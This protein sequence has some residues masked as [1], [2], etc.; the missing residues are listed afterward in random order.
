[1]VLEEHTSIWLKLKLHNEQVNKSSSVYHTTIK[2]ATVTTMV[3]V[4]IKICICR[5]HSTLFFKKTSKYYFSNRATCVIPQKLFIERACIVY[6][7]IN[8]VK[9]V[10]T[11]TSS[12]LRLHPTQW[13][14]K[15]F[16]SRLV[17]HNQNWDYILHANLL[18]RTLY[19]IQK[20]SIVDPVTISFQ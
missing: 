11:P 14:F 1:M 2:S 16:S 20:I 5:L 18:L 12:I 9:D 8:D 10:L 3:F 13:R 7:F 4:Y 17:I 19:K 15:G 6:S